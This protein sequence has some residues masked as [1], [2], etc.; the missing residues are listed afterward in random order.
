MVNSW[1]QKGDAQ[2]EANR[3]AAPP[4][5]P[6]VDEL[7]SAASAA[8]EARSKRMAEAWRRR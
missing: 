4:R 1:R 6:T 7:R 5:T 8:Y 3:D 2:V